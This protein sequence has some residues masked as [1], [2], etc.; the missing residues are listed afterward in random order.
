MFSESEVGFM[1]SE[2]FQVGK[3]YSMRWTEVRDNA[4]YYFLVLKYVS[5]SH[6]DILR[7]DKFIKDYYLDF[8]DFEK[9][10]LVL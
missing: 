5:K 7:E 6:F 4:V 9:A 1:S 10:K 3:L 8:V 2:T